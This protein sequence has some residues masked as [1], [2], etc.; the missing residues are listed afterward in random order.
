MRELI[1]SQFLLGIPAQVV[2]EVADGGVVGGERFERPILLLQ[3]GESLGG[4][5]GIARA[6]ALHIHR[7]VELLRVRWKLGLRLQRG[8]RVAMY[9]MARWGF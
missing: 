7:L 6:A 9:A 4:A 5:H 3:G 8:H 2:G 1:E